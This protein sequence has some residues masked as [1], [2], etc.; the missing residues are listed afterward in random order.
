MYLDE[1]SFAGA[2]PHIGSSTGNSEH[3]GLCSA[4]VGNGSDGCKRHA[5]GSMRTRLFGIREMNFD[6]AVGEKQRPRRRRRR[7][8]EK[9]AARGL[10]VRRNARVLPER[11]RGGGA[12]M[13]IEAKTV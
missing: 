8:V 6:A 4:P 1:L 10:E 3:T 5:H 13:I 12:L 2:A 11:H 7:G 9:T